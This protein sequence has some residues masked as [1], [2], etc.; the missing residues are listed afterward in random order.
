MDVVTANPNDWV[1]FS[2]S[3]LFFS[4]QFVEFFCGVGLIW[5]LETLKSCSVANLSFWVLGGKILFGLRTLD[6][7]ISML[8][9]TML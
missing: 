5:D 3:R 8:V 4:S 7:M 2:Y 1:C 6:F 9:V